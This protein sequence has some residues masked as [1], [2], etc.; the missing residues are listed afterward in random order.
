MIVIRTEKGRELLE[1]TI[2][3][4]YLKLENVKSNVLPESQESPHKRKRP[5]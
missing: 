4:G 1:K 5:L 2:E 3:A